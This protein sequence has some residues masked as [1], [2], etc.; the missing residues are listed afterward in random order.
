MI[1]N[2]LAVNQMGGTLEI[3]AVKLLFSIVKSDRERMCL[4][5]YPQIFWHILHSSSANVQLRKYGGSHSRGRKSYF[6]VHESIMEL[7]LIK[8]KTLCQSFSFL[9]DD[10]GSDESQEDGDAVDDS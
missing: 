6:K 1:L 5:H 2:G 7:V 9:K 8:D 4:L 10:S 3:S